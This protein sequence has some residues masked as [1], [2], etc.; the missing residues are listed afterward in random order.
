MAVC[1]YLLLEERGTSPFPFPSVSH[2]C[3]VTGTGLPIGQR[4]QRTYCLSKHHTLCPLF[5]TPPAE[6]TVLET[7]PEAVAPTPAVTPAFE[8]EAIPKPPPPTIAATPATETLPVQPPLADAGPELPTPVIEEVLP[9]EVPVQPIAEPVAARELELAAVEEGQGMGIRPVPAAP[10]KTH[11]AA[12]ET[13]TARIALR[14][15]PQLPRRALVWTAVLAGV[16]I[17]VLCIGVLTVYGV[18]RVAA[19]GLPSFGTAELLPAALLFL[20]VMSFVVAFV[21]VGLLLWARRRAP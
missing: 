10:V 15:L 13:A 12:K 17:V 6:A 3:H 19:T 18:A 2:C 8:L 21:L 20:S 16:C 14:P 7:I 1:R 9:P 4:E 5:P 11:P